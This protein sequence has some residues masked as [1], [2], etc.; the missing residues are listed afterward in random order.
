[1]VGRRFQSAVTFL[2]CT[3]GLLGDGE[4]GAEAASRKEPL[5]G[6]TG[7]SAGLGGGT[8]LTHT[9]SMSLQKVERRPPS[10]GGEEN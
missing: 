1:M 3:T 9:T 2:A 8:H 5:E 10:S 4:R 7:R 6:A